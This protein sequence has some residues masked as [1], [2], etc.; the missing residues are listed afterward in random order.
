MLN[1]CSTWLL[2]PSQVFLLPHFLL[3]RVI[4]KSSTGP[5]RQCKTV[6]FSELILTHY[7]SS[8]FSGELFSLT[9]SSFQLELKISQTFTEQ[10]CSNSILLHKLTGLHKTTFFSLSPSFSIYGPK[11]TRLLKSTRNICSRHTWVDKK[12]IYFEVKIDLIKN[13]CYQL[14]KP[15]T[16]KRNLLQNWFIFFL[17]VI[18]VKIPLSEL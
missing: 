5:Q 1:I 3:H 6:K 2:I 7:I 17:F 8:L 14:V 4:R 13:Y 16:V 12:C 18:K 10:L 15:L 9:F 11:H